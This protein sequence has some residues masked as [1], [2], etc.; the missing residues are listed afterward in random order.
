MLGLLLLTL[1][2]LALFGGFDGGDDPIA[3]DD[4]LTGDD[5]LS[6]GSSGRPD[7]LFPGAGGGSS[8]GGSSGGGSSGGGYDDVQ[9]GTEA[10][11]SLNGGIWDDLLVGQAGDD[12]LRGGRN[13]DVLYGFAGNDTLKGEA[14]DDALIGGDGNDT[15]WGMD[16]EDALIGNG[17]NDLLL[18]GNADDV[19]VDFSGRDTLNGGTGADLLASIDQSD[20]IT[21]FDILAS[22][23]TPSLTEANF[24]GS[25]RSTFGFDEEL[26]N[27]VITALYDELRSGVRTENTPDVLDGGAGN[28]VLLGDDGDTL[29]GGSGDDLFAVYTDPKLAQDNSPVVI[30]DFDTKTDTLQ[31]SVED[32]GKGA[33][34]IMADPAGLGTQLL[35]RDDVIALIS[36]KTPNDLLGTVYRVSV[37]EDL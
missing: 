26:G 15:V 19:I 16:G 9:F 27:N 33:V 24:R 13:D 11:D 17:G 35:Y 29:T 2:P 4:S 6:G 14:G 10:N 37:R 25:L 7:P 12:S 31:I 23:G 20:K 28:D 34:T 1:F 30:T 32:D 3:D 8:G 5:T 22:G 21:P 36:G 18:G